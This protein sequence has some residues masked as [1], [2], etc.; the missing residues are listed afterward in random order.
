MLA[1]F[2]MRKL[3]VRI[4]IKRAIANPAIKFIAFMG[5]R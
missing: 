2:R 1:A 5:I 4:A 3:I